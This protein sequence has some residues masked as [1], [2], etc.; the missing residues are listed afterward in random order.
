MTTRGLWHAGVNY[1]VYRT[2][3]PTTLPIAVDF[4]TEYVLKSPNDDVED[5]LIEGYIAAMTDAAE[6]QTRC[7][8]KPQTWALVL[9]AFPCSGRIE[10]P[11]RPLIG[12]PEITYYDGNGDLQTLSASPETYLLVQPSRTAP[13]EVHPLVDATF[14]A[15]QARPDAVTVTFEAGFE[16]PD[17]FE[18]RRIITG[19]ALAVGELYK[20]PSL[21]VQAI[22]NTP[23]TLDLNRFWRPF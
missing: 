20:N 11:R 5:L 7:A 18:Y 15:T 9:D 6:S 2:I 19:I 17:D 22:N 23:T 4:V 3:E 1:R 16:D 21:S 14:P 10:L 12:R 13:A 8:L